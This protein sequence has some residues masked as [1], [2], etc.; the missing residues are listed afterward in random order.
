MTNTILILKDAYNEE[1]RVRADAI[2]TYQSDGHL[3]HVTTVTGATFH[4]QNTESEIDNALTES[5]FM[6]KRVECARGSE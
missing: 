5:Y 1:I 6:L 3:T 4:V 2:S